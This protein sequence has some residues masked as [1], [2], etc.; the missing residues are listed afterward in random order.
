MGKLRILHVSES[1]GWSGGAAQCLFLAD[2][3]RN[4][5]HENVIASPKGGDLHLK[6]LKAGFETFDFSPSSKMD[7]K[8]SLV[9]ASFYDSRNFDIVHAH[10]PKAHNACLIGKIFSKSRP[11]LVVSRRVSHPLPSNILARM[12]YKTRFVNAYIPVCD[13][14]ANM[15]KDYGIEQERIFKVYSGTDRRKYRPLPKDF[16]FKKT[17][18]LNEDDFVIS[19]IGNFSCDKG[20]HVFINALE[21]LKNKGI[22]FKAIF[23]GKNTDGNEL[24][25]MFASK[26]D[27]NL[28]VFLGFRNDVEKL[29]NITDVNVNAAIKGEALSGSL[30][31]ALCCAVPSVASNIAGNAEILKDGFNGYLFKPGDFV[32]LAEKLESMIKDRV[33]LKKMSISAAESANEKFS[34]EKMGEETLKVY[35]KISA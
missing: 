3:I 33:L 10:H 15:L 19:L 32:A 35:L 24:K 16:S 25:S 17:L 9:F 27:L 6:A 31:E 5:G 2:Y 1:Y 21:I 22:H 23:A 34:I 14:V 8:A 29:L 12:K 30:R 11:I 18:G 28:G 26:L 13:Y 4:K 20:Q 7:I